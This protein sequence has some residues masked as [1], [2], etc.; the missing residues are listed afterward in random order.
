RTQAKKNY[1][2]EDDDI[3]L[4][5]VLENGQKWNIEQKFA[6]SNNYQGKFVE[7]LSADEFNL[8][9]IQ[10]TGFPNPVVIKQHR[11]LG[12]RVP[13]S[14][15]TVHDVRLCIGSKR[16]I[17]VVNVETQE[18]LQMTMKSWTDY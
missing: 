18:S 17:D 4:E 2:D 15:F 5:E 14:R 7:E 1:N 3:L 8:S 13:T 9:Y 6:A 10:R 16:I 12:L 11:G